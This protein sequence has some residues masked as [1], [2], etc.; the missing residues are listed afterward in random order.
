MA[1]RPLSHH[2][3]KPSGI[4]R[5]PTTAR[6]WTRL[7]AGLYLLGLLADF[8]YR[9]TIAPEVGNQRLDWNDVVVGFQA[10]LFWPVDLTVRWLAGG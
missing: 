9:M 10:S 2:I 8:G 6:E 4:W 3:G 7:L 5:L 1:I